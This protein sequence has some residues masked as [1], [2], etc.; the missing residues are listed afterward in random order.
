[1]PGA[2][3]HREKAHPN[4]QSLYAFYYPLSTTD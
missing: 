3:Q 2:Q 4:L 1:M